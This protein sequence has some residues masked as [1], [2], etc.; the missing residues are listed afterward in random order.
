LEEFD[1]TINPLTNHNL[2]NAVVLGHVLE[3]MKVSK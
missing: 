3:E 2:R 1:G